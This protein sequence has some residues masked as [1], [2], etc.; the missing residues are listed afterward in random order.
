M[1]YKVIL[2]PLALEDLEQICRYIA[3]DDPAAAQRLGMR[4]LA[5]AETLRH[6]P[7]RGGSVTH[8]PGVKKLLV[9]PYILFYRINVGQQTVEVLRFWHGARDPNSLRLG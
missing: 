4:L 9:R 7:H 5:Q 1:V 8:R 3:T 6:L 2:S